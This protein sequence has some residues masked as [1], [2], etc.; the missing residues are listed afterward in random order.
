MIIIVVVVV[1]SAVIFYLSS[2]RYIKEKHK[3]KNRRK[4]KETEMTRNWSIQLARNTHHTASQ[5]FTL[6]SNISNII[7]FCCVL[8][9]S[10]NKTNIRIELVPLIFHIFSLPLMALIPIQIICIIWVLVAWCWQYIYY[11]MRQ[12]LGIANT[13]NYSVID[14]VIT[15]SLKILW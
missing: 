10:N 11:I 13:K 15:N 6:R 14:R 7:H 4:W 2:V 8:L 5:Q 12:A 3:K 9:F 1:F